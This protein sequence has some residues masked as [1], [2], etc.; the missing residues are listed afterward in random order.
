MMTTKTKYFIYSILLFTIL[1]VGIWFVLKYFFTNMSLSTSGIAIVLAMLFSPRMSEIE[2]QT[3]NK[4]Q[5]KWI[6][7]KKVV[8]L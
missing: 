4:M 8:I 5:F 7:S 1:Y 6:F 2:T 3:G